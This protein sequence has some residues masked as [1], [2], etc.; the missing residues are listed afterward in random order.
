MPIFKSDLEYSSQ[1]AKYVGGEDECPF[2]NIEPSRGSG[3]EAPRE[4]AP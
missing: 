3:G 2:L 1:R 4:F